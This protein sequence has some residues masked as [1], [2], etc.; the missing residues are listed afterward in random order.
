MNLFAAVSALMIAASTPHPPPPTI[1][2]QRIAVSRF[3]VSYNRAIDPCANADDRIDAIWGTKSFYAGDLLAVRLSS[4]AQNALDLCRPA[5]ARVRALPLPAGLTGR[6]VAALRKVLRLKAHLYDLRVAKLSALIAYIDEP[7]KASAD[8][9]Y[10]VAASRMDR[11]TKLTQKMLRPM[12]R[13]LG[14]RF[15]KDW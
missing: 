15:P 9:R 7:T 8:A 3:V 10:R 13:S 12:F 4:A 2:Q 6:Q 5:P 14:M 1:P 11:V